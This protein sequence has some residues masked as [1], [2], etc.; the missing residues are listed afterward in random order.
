MDAPNLSIRF[1]AECE[2]AFCQTQRLHLFD[3]CFLPL[4]FFSIPSDYESILETGK[5]PVLYYTVT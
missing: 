5:P 1:A 3:S 4:D 2:F